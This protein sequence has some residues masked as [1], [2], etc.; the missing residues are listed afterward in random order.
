MNKDE[1]LSRILKELKHR[2]GKIIDEIRDSQRG[3]KL[4]GKR[5]SKTGSIYWE[6]RFNRTDAKGKR[7]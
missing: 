3:A 2:S 7:I 6:T 4:P 5:V 1:A